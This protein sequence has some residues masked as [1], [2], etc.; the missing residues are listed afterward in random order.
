MYDGTE[1]YT[2]WGD[3]W[4]TDVTDASNHE[5]EHS[6]VL[7]APVANLLGEPWYLESGSPGGDYVI[8]LDIKHGKYADGQVG[9]SPHPAE[10][11]LVRWVIGLVH[12]S[13][14]PVSNDHELLISETPD[15]VVARVREFLAE[16]GI[17]VQNRIGTV[18]GPDCDVNASANA[19]P[20]R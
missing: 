1:F 7:M 5:H 19:D 20:D 18:D 9:V 6:P 14:H 16:H 3:T 8:W 4:P 2:L 13:K 15:A 11:G 12:N 10:D 17:E